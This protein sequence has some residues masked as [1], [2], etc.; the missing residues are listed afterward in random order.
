MLKDDQ[1]RIFHTYQ[2][3]FTD[4]VAVQNRGMHDLQDTVQSVVTSLSH[5]YGGL[6]EVSLNPGLA[7]AAADKSL[8]SPF[9]F[10]L[11]R[12]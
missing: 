8:A 5:V 12:R 9:C 6:E 1:Q 3:T 7:Q 10:G 11:P 4:A 2:S